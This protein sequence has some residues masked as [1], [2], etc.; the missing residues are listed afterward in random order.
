MI[1]KTLLNK[2]LENTNLFSSY[3]VI[4]GISPCSCIIKTNNENFFLK[5]YARCMRHETGSPYF[6]TS[7]MEFL[8]RRGILTPKP[9]KFTNDSNVLNVLNRKVIIYKML[10]GILIGTKRISFDTIKS[11]A[12][13]LLKFITISSSSNRVAL[14]PYKVKDI[15]H[16]T[17]SLNKA[18]AISEYKTTQEMLKFL[19]H[20]NLENI[21][22][23]S[24]H[25]IVHGNFYQKNI[26][27]TETGLGLINF[28]DSY[29]GALIHDIATCIMEF[30]LKKNAVNYKILNIFLE[31]LSEYFHKNKISME[32]LREV[33]KFNCIRLYSYKI[34]NQFSVER[35][36]EMW[37][38][39]SDMKL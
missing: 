31:T 23:S 19:N 2:I 13:F 28:A 18:A 35:Y 9:I 33:M 32:S 25:G 1:H 34:L 11:I 38:M 7:C 27:N 12:Q 3:T 17:L 30:S 14:Y 15:A 6:E 20:T 10:D 16:V 5:I 37:E 21:L 29:Y 22:H 8:N 26:V 4:P 39:L 24:P 36:Q